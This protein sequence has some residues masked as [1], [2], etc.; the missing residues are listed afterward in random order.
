MR[1]LFLI[2]IFLGLFSCQ[3]KKTEEIRLSDVI[4]GTE[5]YSDTNADSTDQ[6]VNWYDSLS[7]MLQLLCDS[8]ILPKDGIVVLDSNFYVDRFK[9]KAKEKIRFDSINILSLN[10]YKDSIDSKNAFFNW[11]DCFGYPCKSIMLFEEKKINKEEF[12]VFVTEKSLLFLKQK[13][14][15]INKRYLERIESLFI[16]E[17]ILY[18]FDHS[19]GKK[20]VW[21]EKSD[22]DGYIVKKIK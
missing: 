20:G 7:P 15:Q 14:L 16:P 12:Y 21:W 2:F 11:L 6:K 10:V 17:K 19:N 18:V 13:D 1:Y 4:E 22:K 9:N 5:K 3:E 8:L